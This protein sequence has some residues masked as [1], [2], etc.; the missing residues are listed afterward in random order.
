VPRVKVDKDNSR[1]NYSADEMSKLL[2]AAARGTRGGDV[3][4]L[5]LA[6]G[7]RADENAKIRIFDVANDGCSFVLTGGK[8]DN[9]ARFIPLVHEA[10]EIMQR[11][12]K[13][14]H[15]TGCIFPEWPIRPKTEKAAAG[16]SLFRV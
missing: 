15:S 4:C 11:R 10:Q 13:T 1:E 9:A 2:L 7:C 5:A 16:K 8:S 3:L 6:T 12:L 14:A